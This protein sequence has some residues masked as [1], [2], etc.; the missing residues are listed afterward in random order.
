MILHKW[1][2]RTC[3]NAQ[4]KIYAASMDEVA[5]LRELHPQLARHVGPP[6]ISARTS[7][8]LSRPKA[9]AASESGSTSPTP[10]AA[11]KFSVFPCG[12]TVCCAPIAASR[13]I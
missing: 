13:P 3:L 10:P 7:P 6:A 9:P 11:F 2:M 4:E 5:Q 8:P 1:T 12:A